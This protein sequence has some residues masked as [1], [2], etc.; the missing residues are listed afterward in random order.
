MRLAGDVIIDEDA[1]LTI[2]PGTQ[3]IFAPPLVGQDLYQEHPYFIGSELIVRGRLTALGTRQQPILFRAENPTADP[4]SWGG[5]NLE[6]ARASRFEYCVFQQAD[7]A[8]H[9]RETQV[10]IRYSVFRR[11]VVGVRFHDTDLR[12]EE[13]LF[14]D[15]DTAIRFHYGSPQIRHNLIQN[16]RKGLF[17]SAE[18]RNYQIV[19]NAFFANHPYQVNLEAARASRFEYCVFQQADSAVHARQTQVDIR[20]SVFRR[21]LVGVRFHDTDLSVE[22]TLFEDNDTAIRFHYGSPQIRH[23]LIRNNCKGLFI[24]AEPRNYRIEQ[25]AFIDNYPYQV[26][27]GEGVR[28]PVNLAHNFW[29]EAPGKPLERLFFDGRLD[30]WLGRIEYLPVLKSPPIFEF[31]P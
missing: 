16:N 15:N 19:Q 3:V 30:D 11:N 13:T 10:D 14:E 1:E 6:A 28:M 5:V 2:A 23:N 24:S 12:V 17:I 8:V 31:T 25:N 9:A 21:N 27:L 18:P 26:N 20:Y 4:G 7:S 22:Q 29:S